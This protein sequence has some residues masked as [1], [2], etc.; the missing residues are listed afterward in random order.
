MQVSEQWVYD[1]ICVEIM[2]SFELKCIIFVYM[3][4]YSWIIYISLRTN[5]KPFLSRKRNSERLKSWEAWKKGDISLI[6]CA[7]ISY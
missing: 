3:V 6:M 4:E 2:L 5:T 1:V 7:Y